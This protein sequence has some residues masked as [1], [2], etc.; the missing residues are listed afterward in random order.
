MVRTEEPVNKLNQKISSWLRLKEHSMKA[1]CEAVGI[2]RH[3]LRTR[4]AEPGTWRWQEVC[5]AASFL[6]CE[7]SDLI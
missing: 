1:L 5:K 6:G 2:S 7:V 3:T 4:L